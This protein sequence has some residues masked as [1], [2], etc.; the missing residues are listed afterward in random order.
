MLTRSPVAFWVMLAI[1]GRGTKW[2]AFTQP[3]TLRSR[4]TLLR[5]SSMSG[6]MWCTNW[7]CSS[8]RVAPVSWVDELTHTVS[9]S[10]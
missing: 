1:L 3:A 9:E 2:T 10:V 6:V 7:R 5:S 4:I 8:E